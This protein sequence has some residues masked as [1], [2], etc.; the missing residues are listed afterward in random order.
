MGKFLKTALMMLMVGQAPVQAATPLSL[1][2]SLTELPGL[3]RASKAQ[4]G[5]PELMAINSQEYAS[6]IQPTTDFE[7]LY[8]HAQMAQNELAMLTHRVAYLS[9]TQASVPDV[10]SRERAL[11]K[12]EGKLDGDVRLLTDLARTTLVASNVEGVVRAYHHLNQHG[13]VVKVKNRFQTPKANGYRDMNVLVR[14]PQSKLVAEVQIHLADIAA[15]KSG[16]EHDIYTQIQEIERH[17]A[18]QQRDLAEIELAR[19]SRLKQQSSELY[20][21]AWEAHDTPARV[22]YG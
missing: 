12:L 17:A 2:Q 16:A 19:I 3:E 18:Q 11:A 15:I 6:V 8:Q 7:N 20:Q 13:Q 1:N 14:L 21:R 9:S 22:N 5:L 4:K 10:K